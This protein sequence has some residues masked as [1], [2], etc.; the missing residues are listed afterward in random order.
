MYSNELRIGNQQHMKVNG[1]QFLFSYK[2][3]IYDY[4]NL[5]CNNDAGAEM[6]S[7]FFGYHIEW[8][9]LSG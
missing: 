7:N 8:L 9:Q 2:I 1:F 6:I 3:V 5:L 4:E